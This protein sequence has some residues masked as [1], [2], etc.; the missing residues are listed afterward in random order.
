MKIK[1]FCLVASLTLAVLGLTVVNTPAIHAQSDLKVPAVQTQDIP[2]DSGYTDE[3]GKPISFKDY[4]QN[5]QRST[6]NIFERYPIPTL[7]V[8]IAVVSGGLFL[9]TKKRRSTKNSPES[10]A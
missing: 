5:R 2:Q 10:K 1:R 7:L 6:K 3:H 9:L 4:E 8:A